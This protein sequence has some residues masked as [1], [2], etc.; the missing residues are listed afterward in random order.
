MLSSRV[1]PVQNRYVALLHLQPS[2]PDEQFVMRRLTDEELVRV[3]A[4]AGSRHGASK[5]LGY[6]WEL[7][8]GVTWASYSPAE[9][10]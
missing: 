9:H 8:R 10:W 3:V 4:L 7:I 2:P 5:P 6:P 1:D